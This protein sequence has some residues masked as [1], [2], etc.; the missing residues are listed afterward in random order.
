MK[1]EAINNGSH[2]HLP[3]NGVI[4][5]RSGKTTFP[6]AFLHGYCNK[7]KCVEKTHLFELSLDENNND[8]DFEVI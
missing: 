8:E 4:L 7:E 6:T 1:W 3:N 2:T 5:Q